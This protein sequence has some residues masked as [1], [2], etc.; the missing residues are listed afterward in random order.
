[1]RNHDFSEVLQGRCFLADTHVHARETDNQVQDIRLLGHTKWEVA[2]AVANVIL[3]EWVFIVP[4][5]AVAQLQRRIVSTF[6]P[7]RSSNL[8]AAF[9][10]ACVLLNFLSKEKFKKK[11]RVM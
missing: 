4:Q 5:L 2:E 1:V 9:T 8:E 6:G 10:L 7:C 11:I 3:V